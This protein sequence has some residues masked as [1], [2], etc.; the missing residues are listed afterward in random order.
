MISGSNTT[1]QCE[2]VLKFIEKL[3]EKQV[4]QLNS[5]NSLFYTEYFAEIKTDVTP[6]LS[7]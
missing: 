2:N 4:S 3:E 6:K 7:T 1:F 5:K